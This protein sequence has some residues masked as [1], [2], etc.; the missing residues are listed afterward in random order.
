MCVPSWRNFNHS[1]LLLINPTH[2]LG[3]CCIIPLVPKDTLNRSH[4]LLQTS[5][6]NH[7]YSQRYSWPIPPAPADTFHQ[8]HP[9]STDNF[10]Q[11]CPFFQTLDQSRSLV[12]D[13]ISQSCLPQKTLL[14]TP[15][16]S[17]RHFWPIPWPIPATLTDTVDLTIRLNVKPFRRVL[18]HP[19]PNAHLYLKWITAVLKI[20]LWI[21]CNASF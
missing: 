19:N 7:T 8:S 2:S 21:L 12:Q 14:S 1:H 13:N 6:S 20:R 16:H 9:L 5:L 4:L 17:Q 11:S 15:T 3:H 10:D 18:W